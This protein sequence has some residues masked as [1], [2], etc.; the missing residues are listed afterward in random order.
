MMLQ[1]DQGDDYVI[2]TGETH[3]I[4]DL[5]D[6][7]F[8]VVG[9]SDWSRHVGLDPRY[10]RPSEVD[11]LIGDASKASS[12]L[13]WKPKVSFLELVEMMVRADIEG[14]RS[15]AQETRVSSP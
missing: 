12:V 10:A 4:S 9:I 15:A 11:V 14:Q 13:G 3:S 5:L 6:A 8:S 7:A 1:Q 2:A